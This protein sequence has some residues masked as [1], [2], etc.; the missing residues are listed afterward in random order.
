MDVKKEIK[1]LLRDIGPGRMMSTAYD[2]A[3]VA[4][5][6]EL[7]EP[8]GEQALE[9]LREH[10]LPDGSWGASEPRY[11]HDRLICT[12]AAMTALG[13]YGNDKDKTR[14][15]R[16]RLGL[17]IATRGLRADPVGETI[18][19]EMIVPTLLEE[20]KE[21]G[22]IRR[23]SNGSISGRIF[24]G[25]TA[26][27]ALSSEA[28]NFRRRDDV[29][30][31]L[32]RQRAAKLSAL[33]EG[34]INRYVTLAFSA[35]MA[36]LDRVDLL[37]DVNILESNGSIAHSPSATAYFALY[38]SLGNQ[39]AMSYLHEVVNTQKDNGAVPNVAPFDVFERAWTLWN[40]DL[41]E[42]LDTGVLELCQSH[43]DFLENA[44]I[45]SRGMGFAA[46][47]TPKDSDGTSVTIDVLDKYGRETDLETL[48]VYEESDYFRCF[49]LEANPSVSANIHVLGALRQAG[50]APNHI[51]VTKVV[52][53]LKRSR[54]LDSFWMDKWHVSPYYPT[55]HL[56]IIANRY[57]NEF[58]P[59]A[60]QWILDTQFPDGSWGYYVPSLE[61]TAYCLQA[62][63]VL[64]R[65][66]HSISVDVLQKGINWLLK[67]Q[68][69]LYN[70]LWIGKCL[71]SPTLVVKSAVL[72]TLLL[73]KQGGF[74]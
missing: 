54:Y 11:Y 41:A 73:G 21:L 6:V 7:G 37:D 29:L 15:Q 72:S 30:G 45:P 17:D 50:F 48:F 56:L 20:A 26:I 53:F 23:S 62:L 32:S 40:L 2:T 59:D 71:Y 65:S 64:H 9:W 44:W 5:L 55:T 68:D 69:K 19:F 24:S 63:F 3:W 34:K 58:V 52:N 31:K 36:G 38:V 13:R 22:L 14:L 27:E 18:G 16:A 33:P 67:N 46:E 57:V 25:Q 51:S 61:E 49:A 47:Y 10:Q 12:L 43:L 66:G 4:R 39:A 1:Q 35:E 70:P 74:L 8:I 60:L 42:S 28:E